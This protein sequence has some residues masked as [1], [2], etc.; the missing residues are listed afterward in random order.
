MPT[1]KSKPI[2]M[3][4]AGTG[5]A[6]FRSFWQERK[7]DK[8]LNTV[9]NQKFGE[10]CLIF[11]CRNKNLDELY[12]KEIYELIE[13]NIINSYHVGYSRELNMQKVI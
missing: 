11:G 9:N 5:I 2:L 4:G 13:E 7:N 8:M 10:M 12:I 3:I 6:P 1:D